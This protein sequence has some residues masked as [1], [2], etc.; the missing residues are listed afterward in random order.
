MGQQP[1]PRRGSHGI[2][3]SFM[4]NTSSGGSQGSTPPSEGG[5]VR[6]GSPRGLGQRG[7]IGSQH[8]LGSLG[9][10][11]EE[12]RGDDEDAVRDHEE[13]HV[14]IFQGTSQPSTGGSPTGPCVTSG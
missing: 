5:Y 9:S 2:M 14:I 4:F 1:W 8:S 10:V 3:H 11:G 13:H 12:T 7:R 6:H